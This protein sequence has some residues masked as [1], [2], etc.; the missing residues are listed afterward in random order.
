MCSLLNQRY[1]HNK[2]VQFLNWSGVWAAPS[3][4]AGHTAGGTLQEDTRFIACPLASGALPALV[5]AGGVMLLRGRPSQTA[6]LDHVPGLL[7]RSP[8]QQQAGRPPCPNARLAPQQKSSQGPARL[9]DVSQGGAARHLC[10]SNN[11][12]LNPCLGRE[13]AA[14]TC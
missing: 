12:S 1:F 10:T 5:V 9:A 3:L 7:G 14:T 11:L 8:L 4:C 2:R 6:L 13:E